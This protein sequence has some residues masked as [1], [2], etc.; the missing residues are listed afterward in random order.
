[1]FPFHNIQEGYNMKKPWSISTT[2][3]NPERI[4]EFL[5]VLKMI[6]GEEWTRDTQQKY[7]IMLIQYKVYGYG[8]QQFY[9][10]LSKEHFKLMSNSKPITY[11]QAKEILEAKNYTGG[12]DMRGRQSFNPLEKMGLAF[13]DSKNKVKISAV[14]SLFLREDYDLGNVFLKSFLKWQLP[15]PDSPDFRKDDG[16]WTKPFISVLHL[17]FQVNKIWSKLGNNPVGIS[18][19]EFSL[20]VPTLIDFNDIRDIAKEI[21]KFRIGI[22][23]TKED[24]KKYLEK[25]SLDYIKKFLDSDNE[26]LINATLKNTREY[27]DNIIRYFRLTRF[28]RLRGNGY[29][30]DLEPRREIEIKSLLEADSG[31]PIEFKERE[32]YI[33]YLADIDKPLLPWDTT[34]KLNQIA[35]NIISEIRNLEK[36]L[37]IVKF[38]EKPYSTFDKAKLKNYIQELRDVRRDLQEDINYQEF[39]D[40]SNLKE[41]IE[42]L[43]S[44]IFVMD[45]R[46]LV[47]E[48]YITLA[49]NALNDALEIKPN[50]PVGDDNEP[51]NTAPAGEPDIEC[52]YQKFNSIC[53]V[54]LLKD[55][56]QWFNEGQPVMRHLR[57]F[58][59][60]NPKKDAYCV[61]IAP[62]LHVDTIETFWFSI[63]HGYRGK[64]QKIVP[65][66]IQQ[67]IELLEILISMKEKNNFLSHNKLLDLYNSILNLN[68][69]SD[70]GKWINSIPKIIDTWKREVLA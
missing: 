34:D 35:K 53:E 17:I 27:T 25:Y 15:N 43:K 1:M 23:K 68:K 38:K 63:K 54:T 69:I 56:S 10:G 30:V 18:K 5:K 70:S 60:N 33:D 8:S 36:I 64:S 21:I 57:K 41:Y 45:N 59:E 11:Q 40:L 2:V 29:Y 49:L 67:F 37:G 4:R 48:K 6:E 50:Y 61:F 66:T 26:K 51:T 16:F 7:Q 20:F 55:R 14:G 12:G 52:F 3:R 65:L 28:I 9:N 62:S 46:P 22:K 42:I 31:E 44:K 47:L 58:E 39:Q 13:I 19:K 32:D 24:K